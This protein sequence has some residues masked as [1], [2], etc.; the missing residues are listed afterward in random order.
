M[1]DLIHI[2][3]ILSEEVEVDGVKQ[4]SIITHSKVTEL[5]TRY[6]HTLT[7]IEQGS[8]IKYK[9]TSYLTVTESIIG[10]QG[11]FKA[12][13]E[14]C[15]HTLK[16]K[17]EITRVLIVDEFG[18]PIL[19]I[20]GDEQYKNVEGDP[21]LIPSIVRE[22]SF[23][24]SGQQLLIANNQIVIVIKY[25]SKNEELVKVNNELTLLESKW[26]VI[27]VNKI[28]KGLLICTCDKKI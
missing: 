8:L 23:S 26:K 14:H 4:K 17:G 1:E 7:N 5:E 20:Y 25:T 10:R 19:N 6:I 24:I 2:F 21:I 3:N 22:N 27:N 16:F 9:D 28:R 11:K 13:M 15:N 12:I 18:K